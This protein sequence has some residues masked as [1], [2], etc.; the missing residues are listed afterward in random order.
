MTIPYKCEE[1]GAS[2]NIKDELAGT[3]GRCPKCK[4]S[5]VVHAAAKARLATEEAEE[6]LEPAAVSAKS[7]FDSSDELTAA[8]AAGGLS[9]D[10]IEKL[11]EGGG[12]K[13]SED[14][15]VAGKEDDEDEE[16]AEKKS[17]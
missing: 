9:D 1:C 16:P 17:A 7:E 11:L 3:K 5:F 14:Y 15:G 12:E 8:G 4:H 6:P 13:G 10:D 2:L